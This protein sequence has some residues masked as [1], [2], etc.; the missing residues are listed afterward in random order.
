[1]VRQMILIN[2]VSDAGFPTVLAKIIVEYANLTDIERI[3]ELFKKIRKPK[4]IDQKSGASIILMR[5]YWGHMLFI[6][7]RNKLNK[8]Y[9]CAATQEFITALSSGQ[10]PDFWYKFGEINGNSSYDVSY[11]LWQQILDRWNSL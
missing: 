11:E 6:G 4:F 8:I 9:L 3:N 5:D 1:M 2:N 7:K 10:L